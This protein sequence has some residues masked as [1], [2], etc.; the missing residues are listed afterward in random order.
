[1][2]ENYNQSDKELNHLVQFIARLRAE[3]GCPW[4]QEQTHASLRPPAWK[5]DYSHW[6]M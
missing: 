2:N 5:R 6:K 4:D 1:M 3:D